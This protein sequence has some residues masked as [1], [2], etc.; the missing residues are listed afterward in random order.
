MESTHVEDETANRLRWIEQAYTALAVFCFAWA[1]AVVAA[2]YTKAE[3]KLPVIGV[4]VRTEYVVYTLYAFSFLLPLLFSLLIWYHR[5]RVRAGM[6]PQIPTPHLK[7]LPIEGMPAAFRVGA[8]FV[9]IGVPVFAHELA[10]QRLYGQIDI[11][12]KPKKWWR[13]EDYSVAPGKPS[14][15]GV[16]LFTFPQKPEPDRNYANWRFSTLPPETKPRA[17]SEE[18]N[19]GRPAWNKEREPVQISTAPGYV[20]WLFR[21]TAHGSVAVTVAIVLIGTI[22]AIRK[23]LRG[24]HTASGS[25]EARPPVVQ[26]GER[27]E[28]IAAPVG[29]VAERPRATGEEQPQSDTVE[30]WIAKDGSELLPEHILEAIRGTAPFLRLETGKTYVELKIKWRVKVAQ[31]LHNSDGS[32]RL[33]L[34][35]RNESVP[36]IF[37]DVTTEQWPVLRTLHEGSIFDVAG[38]IAAASEFEIILKDVQLT[39]IRAIFG[40]KGAYDE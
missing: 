30:T 2:I 3:P 5:T 20:P 4:V 39:L 22:G 33:R 29:A 19:D 31:F 32:M 15:K 26:R 35:G 1:I 12:W 25:V 24:R 10:Y 9:L 13:I 16:D 14:L 21:L 8:F 36:S 7:G 40:Q 11:V 23:G 27:A 6:P 37:C 28:R 38:T 34:T 18:D 17:L